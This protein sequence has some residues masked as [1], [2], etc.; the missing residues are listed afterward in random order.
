MFFECFVILIKL[1]IFWSAYLS[2]FKKQPQCFCTSEC[3]N[4]HKTKIQFNFKKWQNIHFYKS[5]LILQMS[6][7]SQRVIYFTNDHLLHR[8]FCMSETV[9]YFRPTL[10]C[11]RKKFLSKT[12]FCRQHIYGYYQLE[13][14][15]CLCHRLFPRLCFLN[16]YNNLVNWYNLFYHLF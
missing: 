1:L 10:I 9:P 13:N 15:V 3:F 5:S 14:I 8:T 11:G 12:L 16:W 7:I 4:K 2:R 6:H